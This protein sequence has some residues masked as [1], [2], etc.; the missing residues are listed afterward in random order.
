MASG[1]VSMH[2][3]TPIADLAFSRQFLN[4][5]IFLSISMSRRMLGLIRRRV[6]TV[7]A[8]V[9]VVSRSSAVSV[10]RS[11]QVAH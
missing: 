4:F 3:D 9:P 1:T 2:S 7:S 8:I 5:F 11:V 6:S 10:Y